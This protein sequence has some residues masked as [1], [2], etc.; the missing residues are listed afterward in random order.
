MYDIEK[1]KE[2]LLHK[3]IQ[4]GIKKMEYNLHCER[5]K[6]VTRL[7][8]PYKVIKEQSKHCIDKG[9]IPPNVFYPLNK[10]MIQPF[11]EWLEQNH[12]D[13]SKICKDDKNKWF[14]FIIDN[15]KAEPGQPTSLEK[16]FSDDYIKLRNE[17]E[18][19]CKV[20]NNDT[21]EGIAK[22]KY[23][24]AHFLQGYDLDTFTLF[25]L[26]GVAKAD[27]EQVEGFRHELKELQADFEQNPQNYFTDTVLLPTDEE[28]EVF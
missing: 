19:S 26:L 23:Y 22:R 27:S 5:V 11:L 25:D 21:S 7:G 1:A 2:V 10:S 17:Y 13:I 28:R 6:D 24:M 4:D 15:S 3:Q 9:E 20:F 18:D 8:L 16:Y 14:N 12:P